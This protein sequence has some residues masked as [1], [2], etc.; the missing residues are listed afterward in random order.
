[1]TAFDL[2]KLLRDVFA[3]D[4]RDTA[5]VM[6]DVPTGTIADNP[7]WVE[8]RHMAEIWRQ[9]LLDL[10]VNV[11]PLLEYPA[12]GANNGD[13]PA[14]GKQAGV[15]VGMEAVL[16]TATLVI[17]MTRYS[18]TAPLSAL[19]RRYPALRAASMPNVL[20]RMEQ[21]ALAADYREVARKATRMAEWLTRA[22]SAEVVFA[23]GHRL[24]FDLRFR[25]AHADDGMCRRDKT[26]FRV[27]NLP[28]GEAFIVPY[29]GEIPEEP[30]R[31]AG[32]IPL[33]WKGHVYVLPVERNRIIE[34]RGDGPDLDALRAH[35]ALDPAR[36]NV[37][38]LG[39]GCND[40][41]L[42]TGNV[43]EDEKAGFHWAY[44][45]SEHLGGTVGPDRFS[46]PDHV[47]HH[48]VVYA[49]GCPIEVTRLDLIDAAGQ[50]RT[51]IQD[52][53]YVGV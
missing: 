10:G 51:V 32:E 12:T 36:R 19:T 41:A 47:V 22:E 33:H 43:L 45:R 16:S 14:K 40:R 34:V 5:V 18:A 3:P 38:E 6:V 13:L 46:H 50:H 2:H 23:T 52:G 1:M 7:D 44:G 20:R 30:S 15:T 26:G 35:F 42:I 37:A 29:E 9:G 11:L 17:A 27:I 8:R 49:P 31:T 4:E 28:S 39:L 24:V 21:S 25:I 48:D 53:Q